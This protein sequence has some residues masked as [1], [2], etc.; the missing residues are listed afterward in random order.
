MPTFTSSNSSVTAKAS[1]LATS[2]L[3]ELNVVSQGQAASPGDAAWA[4]EKLQRLIDRINARREMIYNVNFSQY[5]L[6]TDHTPTTIGPGGDFD[7][8]LRPVRLVSCQ[9]VLTDNTPNVTIPMGVRDDDWWAANQIK[10]L[11]ST[12]PTDVYYSPDTPLGN[13]NFWPVP[14]AVNDVILE[15]WVGITQAVGLATNIALPPAYWDYLVL[16]LARDLT[17]SF[18]PGAVEIVSG[19]AFQAN[20]RDALKAM[21]SN[22]ETSHRLQSGVPK[23]GKPGVR[24]GF[25]FLTG[26]PW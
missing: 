10:G 20:Y 17:S 5:T 7:V 12:L 15:T 25:D 6:Q 26:R 18:G 4:L 16:A 14:T 24:P 11:T 13:L 1:E 2:A 8:P 23:S 19:A 21:E 22:N 9:L 3:T